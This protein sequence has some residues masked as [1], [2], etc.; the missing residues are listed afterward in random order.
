MKIAVSKTKTYKIKAKTKAL[1]REEAKDRFKRDE[2]LIKV[3]V[4]ETC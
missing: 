4:K 1:A 3:E 2:K